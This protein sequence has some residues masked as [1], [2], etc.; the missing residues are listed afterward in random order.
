MKQGKDLKGWTVRPW[1]RLTERV[2]E[3][4]IQTEGRKDARDSVTNSEAGQRRAFP[5]HNLGD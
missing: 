4:G 3:S 2:G 1:G 5:P